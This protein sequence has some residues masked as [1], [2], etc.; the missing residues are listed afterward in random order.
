[1]NDPL[2]RLLTDVVG[3]H[4]TATTGAI[5]RKDLFGDVWAKERA[6]ELG[7]GV[8]IRKRGV[9]RV[10]RGCT[11]A[12]C[13]DGNADILTT[14]EQWRD[15]MRQSWEK[16]ELLFANWREQS[17]LAYDRAELYLKKIDVLLRDVQCQQELQD[18]AQ[19]G[20]DTKQVNLDTD[21]VSLGNFGHQLETETRQE[22]ILL[23][24]MAG[25][26]DGANS[27][28]GGDENR[29]YGKEKTRPLTIGEA[30]LEKLR[31]GSLATQGE[32][33]A[34]LR[35]PSERVAAKKGGEL[36]LPTINLWWCGDLM[37]MDTFVWRP[38]WLKNGTMWTAIAKREKL[39]SNYWRY[40]WTTLENYVEIERVKRKPPWTVVQ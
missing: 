34:V 40:E 31:S 28:D 17:E 24:D 14:T 15:E 23:A 13:S 22:R 27:M 3:D 35:P 16:S 9:E 18:L 30:F 29:E 36:T 5:D 6:I 33:G 10:Q 38:P 1:M 21:E 4:A 26:N 32:R 39:E 8:E 37:T 19:V 12:K 11:Q 2:H 20:A 7:G 25:R